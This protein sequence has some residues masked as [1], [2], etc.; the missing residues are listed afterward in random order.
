RG[1][2]MFLTSKWS[3]KWA[4]AAS[5]IGFC[6]GQWVM[7][8]QEPVS[9][10]I[11]GEVSP[12]MAPVAGQLTALFYESYPRLIERFEKPDRSA[13]RHIRLVFDKGLTVPAYCSGAEIHVS[14]EWLTQ[15]PEDVALLTH[16]LTHAVQAYP[17]KGPS[18]MTEGIADYARLIYGPKVQPSWALPARLTQKQSYRNSYRITA[19]FLQWLDEKHPGTVD[20][21]HRLMQE[22][23][24]KLEAF[25]TVTG[26]TADELWQECVADLAQRKAAP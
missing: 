10:T 24:F 5:L 16:E 17:P 2:L 9:L 3:V 18:W 6:T 26:K 7:A 11:S 13:P 23:T 15:H 4:M 14:V 8:A 20:K 25:Q 19:R 22:G 21:L 1:S 12:L